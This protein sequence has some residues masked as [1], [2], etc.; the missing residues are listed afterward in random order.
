MNTPTYGPHRIPLSP[1][2]QWLQQTGEWDP[3]PE[4]PARLPDQVNSA[5]EMLR[6]A[7]TEVEIRLAIQEKYG[8]AAKPTQAFRRALELTIQEQRAQREHLPELVQAIRLTVLNRAIASGQ[9][10]AAAA[11]LRDMSP[12]DAS[13]DASGATLVVEVLRPG[14]GAPGGLLEPS[15]GDPAAA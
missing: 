5:Y 14:S 8:K 11:V 7:S 3:E 9:L 1:A 6:N 2:L 4:A 13:L 15:G 12:V 10:G